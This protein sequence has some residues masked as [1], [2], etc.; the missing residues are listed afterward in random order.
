MVRALLF[1][2]LAAAAL[3]PTLA[4]AQSHCLEQR[5]ENQVVGTI[6]GAGLGAILGGAVIGQHGG[7]EGGAIIGG[8][9][10]AV[11]GNAIASSASHCGANQY[12]YYDDSGRWIPNT[13]T[14]YGYYDP[15]GRW[16]ETPVQNGPP[17]PPPVAYAPA[18]GA[19]DQDA[20]RTFPP[21]TTR[22]DTRERENHLQARIERRIADGALDE[23]Q[24]RHATR[25]LEDIRRIDADYR[26]ADGRLNP[27]QRRDVDARLDALDQRLNA[28]RGQDG[29]APPAGAY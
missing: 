24:G 26:A 7:S 27:D 15:S 28:D 3:T 13:A 29:A 23:R 5:H 14:A 20:P 16:I 10:G 19:Y 21:E 6:L 2:G 18:P 25:D 17:A 8:V 9:G 4:F 12:G 22:V 11:A 1:V